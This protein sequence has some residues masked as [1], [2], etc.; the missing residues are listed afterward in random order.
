MF[1]NGSHGHR[2]FYRDLGTNPI[3]DQTVAATRH[4][5]TP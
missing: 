4:A 1:D 3:D 5:D 2:P